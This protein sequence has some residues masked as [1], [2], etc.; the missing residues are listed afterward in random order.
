[1]AL[2]WAHVSHSPHIA[3]L[4]GTRHIDSKPFDP[5]E[6]PLVISSPRAARSL[7]N[8]VVL[9]H[10]STRPPRRCIV[11]KYTY[12][13][14]LSFV[15]RAAIDIWTIRLRF[16]A[17]LRHLALPPSHQSL[18]YDKDTALYLGQL[19]GN[20]AFLA[21][22]T[23]IPVKHHWPADDILIMLYALVACTIAL[24]FHTSRASPTSV[25]ESNVTLGSNGTHLNVDATQATFRAT[26]ML[27]NGSN[28]DAIDEF[29]VG[30]DLDTEFTSQAYASPRA[31]SSNRR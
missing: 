3:S 6:P 8:I 13:N 19:G 30:I 14:Q 22:H 18:S 17:V 11:F 16:L 1:M 15:R 24:F 23:S 10:I 27:C 7:S 2:L 21:E 9:C 28:C 25:T 4:L 26:L 12:Q 5:R 20:Q 31:S 29:C